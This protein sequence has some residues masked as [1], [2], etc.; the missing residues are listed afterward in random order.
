[1]TQSLA[2]LIRAGHPLV[3]IETT[4][5]PA[6]VQC[7]EDAALAL[8]RPLLRWSV[9]EGLIGMP[10]GRGKRVAGPLADPGKPHAALRKLRERDDAF[11]ALLLDAGPHA[12]DPVVHRLFRDLAAKFAETGGCAVV[13]DSTPPADVLRPFLLRFDLP[14]PTPERLREV[15]KETVR[16]ARRDARRGKAAGRPGK[17]VE[18]KVSESQFT[19]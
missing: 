18:A 8:G 2:A 13:C 7:V 12:S 17:A 14:R 5:E 4:D 16:D 11:V 19:R 3:G 1:M 15:V 9:T 10:E 6:A